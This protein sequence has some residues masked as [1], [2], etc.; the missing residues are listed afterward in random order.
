MR[1]CVK[2]VGTG[3]VTRSAV[4]L[5]KITKVRPVIGMGDD[6]QKIFMDIQG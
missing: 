4:V 1:H 2:L 6:V 3:I 5:I